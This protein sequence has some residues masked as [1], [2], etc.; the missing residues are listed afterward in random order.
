M[1]DGSPEQS[2]GIGQEDADVVELF[3]G[4]QSE[5]VRATDCRTDNFLRLE[6]LSNLERSHLKQAFGVI[7]SLQGVLG[8]RYQAGRF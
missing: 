2:K 5:S 3:A 8:N 1:S 6:E 7:K 4:D